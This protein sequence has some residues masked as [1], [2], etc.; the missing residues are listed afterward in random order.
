MAFLVYLLL[1][2]LFIFLVHRPSSP[3]TNSER[4]FSDMVGPDRALIIEERSSAATIRIDL[5]EGAKSSLRIAYYAVHDGLSSDIFY[6]S[7]IEAAERGVEVELLFD[8]IFH[9][10]KGREKETYWALVNHPNIRVKFYEIPNLFKPWTINNRLHDKF[11]L[12]DDTY[13]LLG[14]RNIGDKYFLE[15]YPGSFVEDRDV[16]VVNTAENLEESVLGQFKLYFEYLW[17][18]IYSW[19]GFNTASALCRGGC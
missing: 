16:L 19:K 14:G 4:F 1:C 7:L 3:K 12:V 11:I 9:N 18:P 2:G 10:L 17:S 13:V 5:I 6:A 15:N 8:G